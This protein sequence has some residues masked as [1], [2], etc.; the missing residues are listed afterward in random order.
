M[1][2]TDQDGAVWFYIYPPLG[3]C[4]DGMYSWGLGNIPPVFPGRRDTISHRV[5]GGLLERET[6][7]MVGVCMAG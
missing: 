5:S 6:V 3:Y 7:T 4:W 1:T 2:S